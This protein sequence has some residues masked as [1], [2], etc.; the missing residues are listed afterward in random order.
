M[1]FTNVDP[2]TGYELQDAYACPHLFVTGVLP[3]P[4]F[5]L[6]PFLFHGCFGSTLVA[7]TD[8]FSQLVSTY[9]CVSLYFLSVAHHKCVTLSFH[10]LTHLKDLIKGLLLRG[11]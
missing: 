2:K 3:E 8:S 9:V 6:N 10:S 5:S 7:L 4:E 1:N 11:T